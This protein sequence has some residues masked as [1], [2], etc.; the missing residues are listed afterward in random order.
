MGACVPKDNEIK[1]RHFESDVWAPGFFAVVVQPLCR[2]AWAS[3]RIASHSTWFA[4]LNIIAQCLT[5]SLAGW[6]AGPTCVRVKKGCRN[7]RC[8]HARQLFAYSSLSLS[9][10]ARAGFSH[11]SPTWQN[12]SDESPFA[13][14]HLYILPCARSPGPAVHQNNGVDNS[15]FFCVVFFISR[16]VCVLS[17]PERWAPS[18]PRADAT[19]VPA[20]E[21][22]CD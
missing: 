4:E 3:H 20:F 14:I 15:V 12:P 5:R 22:E 2:L 7:E 8:T 16:W 18:A 9:R 11:R 21:W 13:R 10:K 19:R 17:P 6:L 1:S